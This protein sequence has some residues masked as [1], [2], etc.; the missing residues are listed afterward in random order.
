MITACILVVIAAANIIVFSFTD[1]LRK[2]EEKE[3]NTIEVDVQ[4]GNKIAVVQIGETVFY[5]NHRDDS[6]LWR[7]DL[8]SGKGELLT[9]DKIKELV[10]DGERLFYRNSTDGKIYSIL[11]DGSDRKCLSEVSGT[12][13]TLFDGALYFSGGDGIYKMNPD[14]S[15]QVQIVALSE[16]SE[17]VQYYREMGL[18]VYRYDINITEEG[19]IYFSAG[20]GKG[21]YRVTEFKD[22][23][24]IESIYTE[25]AY[26]FQIVEDKLYFDIK[27]YA[28]SA[29]PQT[30]LY[31]LSPEGGDPVVIET[32]ILGT[33]AFYISDKVIYF[34]GCLTENP[35]EYGIYA[36]RPEDGTIQKISDLRASD[37]YVTGDRVYLYLPDKSGAYLK[38]LSLDGGEE[39][40]IF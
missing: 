23:T 14:G 25:E 20:A 40:N 31:T 11:P 15:D 36:M 35:E 30:K 2:N 8:A 12:N 21:I 4:F 37:I 24:G 3:K 19:E 22:R 5:Q 6:H 38:S 34:D 7:M 16:N 10:T 18:D 13:I 1:L 33:G 39:I 29:A 28:D 27:S 26:T 9:E 32:I 17:D